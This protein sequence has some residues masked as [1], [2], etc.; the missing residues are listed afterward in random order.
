MAFEEAAANGPSDAPRVT[1]EPDAVAYLVYTSGST[2]RPKGVL[3]THRQI[4]AD[5]AM[6]VAELGFCTDEQ[7]PCSG[8]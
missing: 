8:R 4:L 1:V 5:G 3:K 7:I 2:G 6:H